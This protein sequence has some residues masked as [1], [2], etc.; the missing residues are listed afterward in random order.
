MCSDAGWS[1]ESARWNP[2]DSDNTV[3][4]G[5]SM[6]ASLRTNLPWELM[7]FSAHERLVVR[8]FA[9]DPRAFPG[10]REVLGKSYAPPVS[11]AEL[12]SARVG[13]MLAGPLTRRGG[14]F[15]CVFFF[16]LV[17]LFS[18]GFSFPFLLL[19]FFS[20]NSNYFLKFELFSKFELFFKFEHF[21]ILNIFMF[22][23][24]YG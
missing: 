19:L 18:S 20:Y 16:F 11:G 9:G 21:L 2:L 24:F 5:S 17:L 12:S 23:H 6:Y 14:L 1:N 22:E 10:H 13:A 3:H 4:G 7:G 8:V 15:L